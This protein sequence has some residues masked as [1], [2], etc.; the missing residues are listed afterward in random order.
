MESSDK[1]AKLEK[2]RLS[3]AFRFDRTLSEKTFI[4]LIK[5]ASEKFNFKNVEQDNQ[6]VIVDLFARGNGAISRF[7]LD[8]NDFGLITGRYWIK[9]SC[10]ENFEIAQE[11]GETILNVVVDYFIKK[12]KWPDVKFDMVTC[13]EILNYSN[14]MQDVQITDTDVVKRTDVNWRTFE[15]NL[16]KILARKKRILNKAKLEEKKE[17]PRVIDYQIELSRSDISLPSMIYAPYCGFAYNDFVFQQDVMRREVFDKISD[18]KIINY[19]KRFFFTV[20]TP[21]DENWEIFVDHHGKKFVINDL[22]E[23]ESN[24]SEIKSEKNVASK[25]TNKSSAEKELNE[26]IGLESI[27]EELLL[28][29]AYL[30]KQKVL[31]NK[32]NMNMCFYGNPGTGK[33]EVARLVAK[34]FYKEGFLANN[35]FVETDR[36][37]LVAQYVGQTAPKVHDIF[38]KAMGGV[39]FIDEA[40]SLSTGSTDEYGSEAIAALLKDMEDY[41][42]KICVILAGYKKEME[43]LFDVNPGFRSRINRYIDFPDYSKAEMHEII[44]LIFKK[45]KYICDD[46]CADVITEIVMS[47]T[48][49]PNFANAR[50][51]RNVIERICEIQAL[52]TYKNVNDVTI[53][54]DDVNKYLKGKVD[55]SIIDDITDESDESSE[56]EIIQDEEIESI[57]CPNCGADLRKQES[58][59][60]EKHVHV[61]EECEQEL[62]NPNCDD[63]YIWHCNCCGEIMNNQDDWEGDNNKKYYKCSN[64]GAINDLSDPNSYEYW[65]EDEIDEKNDTEEAESFIEDNDIDSNS[66]DDLIEKLEEY[67]DKYEEIESNFDE[68]NEIVKDKVFYFNHLGIP[69][70]TTTISD[71]VNKLK[72]VLSELFDYNHKTTENV[73]ELKDI[74][75]TIKNDVDNIY[76]RSNVD[77][78][79][80]NLEDVVSNIERDIDM[81]NDEY[82]SLEKET[83]TCNDCWNE[84]ESSFYSSKCPDCLEK[85]VDKVKDYI[86]LLE[87]FKD[88]I[89][90]LKSE[91]ESINF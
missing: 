70:E 18:E 47:Q 25:K 36:S 90:E 58:F 30:K 55:T 8:F 20:Q 43:Q 3:T 87:E 69:D 17:F 15:R 80:S 35:N 24:I 83:Y 46:K 71:D 77:S 40:Y 29:K 37:G 45:E 6:F 33:T 16:K 42:G 65:N 62:L 49:N 23:S 54:L 2:R 88:F 89:N 31:G 38:K 67:S 10:Q 78:G 4:K 44:K 41:R 57:P 64:C 76:Y 14:N 66:F 50:T 75:N 32:I 9:E 34:I 82:S 48:N 59:N 22:Q 51:A 68:I 39:L 85:D 60:E 26:L 74:L 1:L 19:F 7:I 91:A 56:S 13:K 81:I 63:E 21:W 84:F 27:K 11:F 12:S 5:K 73:N 52:R 28:M 53:T 79:I 86:D 72:N 61:C